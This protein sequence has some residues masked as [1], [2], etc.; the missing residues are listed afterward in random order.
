MVWVTCGQGAGLGRPGCESLAFPGALGQGG[1]QGPRRAR[2]CLSSCVQKS[3]QEQGPSGKP[4][5]EQGGGHLSLVM[6]LGA[7]T[8]RRM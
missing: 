7:H 2:V 4:D 3:W 5:P 8:H 1:G 6:M